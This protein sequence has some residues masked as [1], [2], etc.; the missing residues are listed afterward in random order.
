MNNL[1]VQKISFN[2]LYNKPP[3]TK[4][5]KDRDYASVDNQIRKHTLNNEKMNQ[6]ISHLEQEILSMVL[7]CQNINAEQKADIERKIEIKK[8]E[9]KNLQRLIEKNRDTSAN[10]WY[11]YH[12]R[13]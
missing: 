9:I 3:R 1:I 10:L 12:E 6:Q 2:G 5:D 7:F 4:E 11:S 8:Q 13:L